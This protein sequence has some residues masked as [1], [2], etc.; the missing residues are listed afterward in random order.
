AVGAGQPH[1]A[2][3]GLLRSSGQADADRR[4][5]QLIAQLM[6]TDMAMDGDLGC[7]RGQACS[8]L[9]GWRVA[10]S[11]PPSMRISMP[12]MNDASCEARKSTVAATSSIVPS[13][14]SGVA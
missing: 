1:R 6:V 4:D 7:Q 10:A 8:P 2:M 9:N 13:R 14:A 11:R 3:R 5:S 12:L